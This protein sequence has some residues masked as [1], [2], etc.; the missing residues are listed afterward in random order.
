MASLCVVLPGPVDTATGGYRYDRQMIAG[1]RALQWRVD[2]HELPARFPFPDADAIEA[3][4]AL[5]GRLRDGTLVLADGLAYGVLADVVE[6]HAA[7]LRIAALVHHPLHAETGL[8][9]AQQRQ[10]F[11]DERRALALARRVF[12]TSPATGAMMQ[13]SG[14]VSRP[15]CVVVPGTTPAPLRP[16]RDDARARLLC[17]ATLPPR[18]AHALLIESLGALRALPWT[19]TCVGST[20]MNPPTTS[21]LQAQIAALGLD[22]RVRLYGECEP[23]ELRELHLH[24]DVFVLASA[25][26]GYGMAVA[27]ALAQGLPVVATRTG[28]AAW[29][30]GDAG[31]LVAPGDGAALTDALREVLSDAPRREAYAA[32][33]RARSATLPRWEDGAVL[34]ADEL[35]R[36]AAA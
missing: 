18:K 12:V 15:P 31:L 10:L 7:R 24:S 9:E 4:R 34:L 21:A 5:F 26:E 22:D 2:V 19:L 17:V 33:A 23:P 6:P 27:E 30:V 13:A 1:L 3:A 29:L 36:L 14:L 8:T 20:R 16:R 11:D 28:A 25:F 35:S 32:L